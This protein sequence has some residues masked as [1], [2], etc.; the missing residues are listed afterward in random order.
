MPE[1]N[2]FISLL[3]VL[4][5]KYTKSFSNKY[6]N[7][8]PYKDS[9]YGLS[10]MLYDYQIENQ[11]I[12]LNEK[13]EMLSELEVPFIVHFENDFIIV[14][15]ISNE[16]IKY[17]RRNK[18]INV[19]K[20]DFISKWSGITLL[21]EANDF[22]IEPDYET[23][24]KQELGAI[25]KKVL[26]VIT[27]IVFS[28]IFIFSTPAYLFYKNLG[29]L[30]INICGLYICYLL[31]L[32]QMHIHSNQ[33]DKICSLLKE[34][35][36]CNNILHTDAAKILGFSW[37][38]IGL[39]YFI[40]NLSIIIFSPSLYNYAALINIFALPYTIWSVWYQKFKAKQWCPLCLIVQGILWLLFII[41]LILGSTYLPLL[42]IQSIL[43]VGCIYLIPV[44][45]LN[46]LTPIF[47]GNEKNENTT[48][49]INSLKA[50][51]EIFKILL[52]D[53]K[54]HEIDKSDSNILL[55]NPD[56]KNLITVITNPYC[57]ACI[58]MHTQLETLLKRTNNGYC[59][60]YVFTPF[61]DKLED[62]SKFLIFMYYKLNAID[63][64][65]LLKDWLRYGKD[66]WEH[67]Y[68]KKF[69]Y[70]DIDMLNEFQKHKM[71][72]KKI[73]I[74]ATPTILFNGYELPNGYTTEILRF[75][76]DINM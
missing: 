64:L 66:H 21:V 7:E 3:E 73:N 30:L 19:S 49:E 59:I 50:N 24:Y 56:A 55:G 62:H 28:G 60:Q 71:L 10:K 53:K 4:K 25:I 41:N 2:I 70:N 31:L 33:A 39:G 45:V 13:Q 69:D 65:A 8:Y 46:M 34:N 67:F 18:K 12:H 42:A 57:Y 1:K 74:K 58:Q 47:T 51:E 72:I 54:K 63:F 38:E 27:I 22:S 5:I 52:K 20:T 26:L 40:A 14:I 36:D 35:N 15:S 75:F 23:H 43:L 61:N 32:K 11:S 16:S 44:L 6:Y 29:G 76:S 9:L 37:S 48:Q 17:I 68:K